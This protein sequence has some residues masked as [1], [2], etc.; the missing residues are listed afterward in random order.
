MGAWYKSRNEPDKN[1]FPERGTPPGMDGKSG[2]TSRRLLLFA[3]PLVVVVAA[4]V[5][6]DWIVSASGAMD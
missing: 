5:K 1:A 4:S 6:M 2:M 3:L